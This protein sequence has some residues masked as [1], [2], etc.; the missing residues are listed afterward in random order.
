[1]VSGC[2]VM[3]YYHN[4][5]QAYGV[6]Y[7]II[8][9][10]LLSIIMGVIRCAVVCTRHSPCSK[11]DGRSGELTKRQSPDQTLLVQVLSPPDSSY[12]RAVRATTVGQSEFDTPARP[13]FVLRSNAIA[14]LDTSPWRSA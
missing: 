14:A 9:Y 7:C 8:L 6:L 3:L 2:A 12:L 5:H 1:M 10:I 13:T 11:V 4:I